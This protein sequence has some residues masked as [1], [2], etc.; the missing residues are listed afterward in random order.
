[1]RHSESSCFEFSGSVRPSRRESGDGAAD[2]P[3]TDETAAVQR[4][5]LCPAWARLGAGLLLAVSSLVAQQN[6]VPGLVD[7]GRTVAL[8]GNRNPQA[9]PETGQ[10]PVPASLPMRGMTLVAR[11]SAA[12]AAALG[13]LLEEQQDPASPNYP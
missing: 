3:P 9:I 1:M 12:Q 11:P 2:G 5:K 6:R 8:K 7:T 13:Q 10:G 4:A